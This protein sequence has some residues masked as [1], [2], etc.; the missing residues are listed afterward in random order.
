MNE[1]TDLAGLALIVSAH[2]DDAVFSCGEWMAARPG[3]QVVTVFAGSPADTTVTTQW[4]A[5]CGFVNARQA[6]QMR[7]LEDRQAL[8]VL[9]ARPHWLEHADDQY[10]QARDAQ[11]I[12][13]TLVPV[14]ESVAPARVLLP[15]GL[16]HRDHLLAHEA[17]LQALAAWARPVQV[18]AYE[19]V[20]YRR[21]GGLLQNRLC[22]LRQAGVVATPLPDLDPPPGALKDRA[23]SAYV[24]QWRALGD[25]A[26]R[27]T[28]RPERFWSIERPSMER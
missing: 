3:A 17:T 27:D 8:D 25:E 19:D 11:Q 24:S 20:P 12:A 10:G 7:R 18:W 4:D 13:A 16:F 22:E 14:L 26:R 21:R 23:V 1:S 28:R 15:L 9:G 6:L 2:L 5:A